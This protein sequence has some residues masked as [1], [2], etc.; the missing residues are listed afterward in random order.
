[1]TKIYLKMKNINKK[2]SQSRSKQNSWA[3]EGQLDGMMMMMMIILITKIKHIRIVKTFIMLSH[4]L[5][6]KS[7]NPPEKRYFNKLIRN[8]MEK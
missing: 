4:N 6:K 5:L 2:N 3:L 8:L 1:M 7:N